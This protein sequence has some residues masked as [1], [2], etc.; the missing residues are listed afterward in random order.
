MKSLNHR[1]PG[2]AE[3]LVLIFHKGSSR[4]RDLKGLFK[5]GLVGDAGF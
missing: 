4:S 2:V 1:E 3:N 5:K